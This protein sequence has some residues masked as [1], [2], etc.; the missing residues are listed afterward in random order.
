MSDIDWIKRPRGLG[1]A[2]VVAHV[3][4]FLALTVIAYFV[5]AALGGHL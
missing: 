4:G 5:G 2:Y 1:V 3:L